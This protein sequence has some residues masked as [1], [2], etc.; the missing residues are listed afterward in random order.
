MRINPGVSDA[1]HATASVPMRAVRH[2][3]VFAILGALVNWQNNHFLMTQN[4]PSV[5]HGPS[6]VDV[7]LALFGL[8]STISGPT[9]PESHC[10][11]VFCC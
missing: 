9:K 8:S 5:V 1:K 6:C 2:S 3:V 11:F 10:S 7:L 4:P